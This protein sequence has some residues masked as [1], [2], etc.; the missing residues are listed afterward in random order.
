MDQR[1]QQLTPTCYSTGADRMSTVTTPGSFRHQ[2]IQDYDDDLI[3]Y[4]MSMAPQTTRRILP[5]ADDATF[6]EY[7]QQTSVFRPSQHQ[8]QNV[9]S[10]TDPDL[11]PPKVTAKVDLVMFGRAGEEQENE[12]RVVRQLQQ[13]QQQQQLEFQQQ[14][15]ALDDVDKLKKMMIMISNHEYMVEQKNRQYSLQCMYF[16]LFS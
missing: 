12:E 15:N 3:D 1:Q 4:K 11:K 10:A 5:E 7:Y 16:V 6:Y 9:Q 8:H 2:S 14:H 13:Q